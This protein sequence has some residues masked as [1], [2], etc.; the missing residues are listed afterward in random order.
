[1]KLNII[2]KLYMCRYNIF[3]LLFYIYKFG[4]FKFIYLLDVDFDK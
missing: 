3:G 2:N 1:M 4:F